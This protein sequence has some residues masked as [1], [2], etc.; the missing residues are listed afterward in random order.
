MPRFPPVIG[1]L[2]VVSEEDPGTT[3]V[4]S[5]MSLSRGFTKRTV[6]IPHNGALMQVWI[7]LF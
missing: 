2:M 4:P 3:P 5:R 7:V 1:R 6:I